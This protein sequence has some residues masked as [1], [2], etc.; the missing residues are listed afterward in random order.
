VFTR[1]FVSTALALYAVAPSCLA[2]RS[3]RLTIGSI[4]AQSQKNQARKFDEYG[5]VGECDEGAR[6]DNFA[7]HLLKAPTT[8]GYI[9][10]YDGRETLPARVG[11]RHLRALDYLVNSRGVDPN[12]LVAINGGFREAAA[13]ELWVAPQSAPAPEPSETIVVKRESGQA[14]KYNEAYP[15]T[16]YIPHIEFYYELENAADAGNESTVAEEEVEPPPSLPV[17]QSA[18]AQETSVDDKD[19][20]ENPDYLWASKNYA[21]AVE[22]ENGIAY[23]IYYAQHEDCHLFQLQQVIEGGQNLLVK[24]YGV[25][26]ERIK[27]VFGGYRESTIIEMW[28]V[29]PGASHPMPTPDYV[30]EDMDYSSGEVKDEAKSSRQ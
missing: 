12:R 21:Q 9:I 13:T 2:N 3:P 14:F 20:P 29:P 15:E 1:A 28:V 4:P 11:F 18:P 19:E 16:T 17:E 6:L 5:L 30:K 8:K 22:A 26:E 25:K 7:I 10:G 23:V 24:K 27:T